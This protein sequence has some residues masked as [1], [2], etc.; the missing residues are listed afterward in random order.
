MPN[1][2]SCPAPNE[3]MNPP[4]RIPELPNNLGF[5]VLRLCHSSCFLGWCPRVPAMQ[6]RCGRFAISWIHINRPILKLVLLIKLFRKA[7]RISQT[8]LIIWQIQFC[9]HCYPNPPEIVIISDPSYTEGAQLRAG[10]VC[11]V[12]CQ[13]GRVP[14]R[15]HWS[16]VEIEAQKTPQQKP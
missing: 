7:Q 15:Y 9:G 10:I 14:H 13:C 2:E 12:L 4:R 5:L 6:R 1:P 11:T 16:G 3:G 8:S